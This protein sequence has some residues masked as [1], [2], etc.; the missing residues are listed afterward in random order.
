MD[1]NFWKKMIYF[2]VIMI[3]LNIINGIYVILT[4]EYWIG[5][6]ITFCL[7]GVF[8]LGIGTIMAIDALKPEN[9]TKR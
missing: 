8:I 3:I 7:F 4:N 2:N 9:F 5:T 6:G 1:K